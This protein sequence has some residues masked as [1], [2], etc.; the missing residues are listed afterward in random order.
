MSDPAVLVILNSPREGT[1]TFGEVLAD[2]GIRR[3]EVDLASGATIPDPAHFRAVVIM[4]GP[5]SAN[6]QTPTMLGELAA[7]R[8]C[9]DLGIPTLG[10]CLGLQ[11]LVR[12]SGGSVIPS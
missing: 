5:A 11:V 9:L 12:A 4:G 3:F 10:V 7:A 6:D 8:R 1:G 2:R